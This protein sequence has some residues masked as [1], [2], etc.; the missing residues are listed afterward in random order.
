[1]AE[2]NWRWAL[3]PNITGSSHDLADHISRMIVWLLTW[4]AQAQTSPEI[5]GSF[6]FALLSAHLVNFFCIDL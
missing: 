4:R 1:M 2:R 5:S 3:K 6:R